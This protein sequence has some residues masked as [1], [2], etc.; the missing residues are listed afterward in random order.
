MKHWRSRGNKAKVQ[1]ARLDTI[2]DT[3]CIFCHY[4]RLM[5][6]N[7]RARLWEMVG[8]NRRVA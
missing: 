5:L 3:G 4:T 6:D 2:K 1:Q 7:A 8:H